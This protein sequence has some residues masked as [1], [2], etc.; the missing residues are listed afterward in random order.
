MTTSL[1]D[2][3]APAKLNLFLH[4]TG[5]RPDGYHALQTVFQLIDWGD[6][7]HFARRDDGAIRRVN[8]IANVPEDT[9][10]TVRAA[11][12]LQAHT[13]TAFGADIEIDKRLPMGGGIGGGSSD[14]ATTLLALNRLW[15]TRVSR[16]DLQRIA[17][18]LGADVPFFIFGE[19]AFAGGVGE[20]LDTVELPARHFLVIV[21][22]AHVPTVEIFSDPELTRDSEAVTITDFLAQHGSTIG[23][24]DSFG[25]NDMQAVVA[26]K[27]AEVAKVL[28]WLDIIAAS[29]MTGSGA[30][31]FAAFPSKEAALEA[32][33]KVPPSWRSVVTA[34]LQRHPLY[35]F[36][37]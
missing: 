18:K 28:D 10:L 9:D 30:C 4:I 21:P 5:R 17:L 15:D 27:Y 14:A 6:V 36:A 26:K 7:L 20:E 1:R 31:V 35:S 23:W 16:K 19:N 13:G 11:R 3:A 37:S 12:L 29:R 34:S 33:A 2:C 25:R 22:N 24:P 8:E 32:Q